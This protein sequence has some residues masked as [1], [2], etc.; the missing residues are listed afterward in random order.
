MDSS[1]TSGNGRVGCIRPVPPTDNN[2][3]L[4]II[5]QL[6]KGTR[7]EHLGRL[8]VE[9]LP[10]AQ[11]M[12]PVRGLSPTLIRLPVRNLFLPLSRSLPLS[13]SLMNE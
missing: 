5:K 9:H 2:Y 11:G 10:L 6:S 13:V 3:K 8:V 7:E 12:I 4:K 1:S